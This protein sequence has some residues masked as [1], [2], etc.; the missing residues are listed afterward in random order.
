MWALVN[1]PKGEKGV[2]AL[3]WVASDLQDI[4]YPQ[5]IS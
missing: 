5:Q 3:A 2:R 4:I 1:L